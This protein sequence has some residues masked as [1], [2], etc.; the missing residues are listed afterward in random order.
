MITVADIAGSD[1][2][3]ILVHLQR[4]RGEV[5]CFSGAGLRKL[6]T[7]LRRLCDADNSWAKDV[8]AQVASAE[9]VSAVYAIPVAPF[10]MGTK[11]D[12]TKFAIHSYK[13]STT[14]PAA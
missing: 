9:A 2:P 14:A 13:W 4:N 5:V 6:L 1:L 12:G 8:M 3:H 11:S 7:E 10:R